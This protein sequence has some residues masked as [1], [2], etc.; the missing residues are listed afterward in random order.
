MKSQNGMGHLATI[1]C[2]IIIFSTIFGFIF[3]AKNKFEQENKQ[4]YETDMLLIQGKIK[5]IS[6]E[7]AIKKTEELI[8]GKKLEENLENEEIMK[9]IEKDIISQE[10]TDFSKYYYLEKNDL[11]EIGLPNI[12][13]E[14]GYYIV[15]YET[16]EVIYSKGI[17]IKDNIYYKLSELQALNEEENSQNINEE[18]IKE[19]VLQQVEE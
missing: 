14:S 3:Y 19:N 4:N 10:D 18:E 5:V 2:I 17:E 11:D 13:L 6:Q 15:N 1:I 9:L 16:Y 12:K 8:K 7:V